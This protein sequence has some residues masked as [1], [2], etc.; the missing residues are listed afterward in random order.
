[1][2]IDKVLTKKLGPLPVGVWGLIGAGGIVAFKK[3]GGGSSKATGAGNYTDAAGN[4]YDANGNLVSGAPMSG[5]SGLGMSGGNGGG[6]VTG[7][8]GGSLGTGSNGGDNGLV[9]A[10]VDDLFK[11]MEKSLFSPAGKHKRHN[12]HKRRKRGGVTDRTTTVTHKLTSHGE[13]TKTHTVVKHHPLRPRHHRARTHSPAVVHHRR[14]H[15]PA[16]GGGGGGRTPV[17]S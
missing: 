4:T 15:R 5:D 11:F 10:V 2:Q 8:D 14:K 16:S 9:I 6:S 1:M 12:Q 7:G 3:F 17:A 13:V